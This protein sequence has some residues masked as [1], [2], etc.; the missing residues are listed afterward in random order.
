MSMTLKAVLTADAS[1]FKGE[2]KEAARATGELG[3]K[4]EEAG[5]KL[6][7][8]AQEGAA[9]FGLLK[10]AIAG[11]L[12]V[13]SV[14]AMASGVLAIT[15]ANDA[16]NQQVA[17]LGMSRDAVQV[18]GQAGKRAG[19]EIA[20]VFKDMQEKIGE[21]A[22]TGGG[23]A[24][25]VFKRLKLDVN[26]LV[27]LSP[28]QQLLKIAEAMSKVKDMSR[29]EK[30]F[31]L[32]SL[33]NDATKLL[34]LLDN[35]AA[36]LRELSSITFQSGA[37][38][39]E[40]QNAVLSEASD[41]INQIQLALQGVGN[42]AG[43]AGAELLN[44]VSGDVVSGII[45]LKDL[46]YTVQNDVLMM[47]DAWS[48]ALASADTDAQA[49]NADAKALFGALLEW[50]RIGWTYFP[51]WAG[52]AYTAVH[53]YGVSFGHRFNALNYE[54][55]AVWQHLFAE[56]ADIAGSVFGLI[57][58]AAG[59]T[60][61]AIVGSIASSLE[62]ASSALSYIPGLDTLSGDLGAAA[63]GLRSME[64][65]A[66]SV[67]DGI[68]ASMAGAAA[69]YREAAKAQE[70]GARTATA[71]ANAA[72]VNA[73]YAL[74]NAAAYQQNAEQQRVL[75]LEMGRAERQFAALG[76]A[77]DA[78]GAAAQRLYVNQEAVNKTLQG[79]Q[80]ASKSAA[81]AAKGHADAMKKL[82]APWLSGS[83]AFKAEIEAAAKRFDVDANL[84]K[85]VIQQE[86]GFLKSA[87]SQLKAV[88]PVGAQGIMQLMPPT[89]E[90]VAKEIGL[91]NY[92]LFNA[93][94][95]ITLGAAYLSQQMEKYNGDVAK[96]AAA[97]NAGPG[98]VDKYAGIPP[99]KETQ[100][101]VKNVMGYY[102]DLTKGVDQSGESQVKAILKTEEAQRAASEKLIAERKRQAERI[103]QEQQ[104]LRESLD[105]D[106][107]KAS[108]TKLGG[109]AIDLQGKGFNGDDLQAQVAKKATIELEGL[110]R[111]TAANRA[112][113]VLSADAYRV[114]QLV[115]EEG[116]AP[117]VAQAQ[118]ALEGQA[119][120]LQ[121][122]RGVADKAFQGIGDAL[123]ATAMT[124]KADW[125]GLMDSIISETMRLAVIQPFVKSLSDSFL[126]LSGGGNSGGN[127]ILGSIGSAL[128]LFANGGAFTG[129]GVQAFADGGAFHNSVLTRPTQF[130]ANGG[131]AVAGEAGDEAVM[132]LTR[133]NGQLGV[134]AQVQGGSQPAPVVVQ[135]QIHLH[136]DNRSSNAT[137]SAT[138]ERGSDGNISFR[139]VV[140]QVESSIA[141]RARRGQGLANIFRT[142]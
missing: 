81:E 45:S 105:T 98:A 73:Q 34:P 128:G 111:A 68:R 52:A 90:E 91:T 1:G 44:A 17:Y 41:N 89:A 135:P 24:A 77:V 122:L 140:D 31:L 56:M 84:V 97:Y 127:G 92:N 126:S 60:A 9:A 32:E 7:R 12:G 38:L 87:Q 29:G 94:D 132:P 47:G 121:D 123:L 80:S 79:S 22:S 36:K 104:K 103:A 51:V 53:E 78:Q 102:K 83:V 138:E 46:L 71:A 114:W 39:D 95:N 106:L 130:F 124:G 16:I 66:A 136:V 10:G 119:K 107:A 141:D 40:S 62:T 20:D 26:D 50:M 118:V 113:A 15:R 142:R 6:S 125:K 35:N 42:V 59:S 8:G 131:L 55:G 139:L 109:F 116:F 120:T 134:M 23:E 101:Y 28:D 25:D 61:A 117:S 115:N 82:D 37:I 3:G 27:S 100:T 48:V 133:I 54:L 69:G 88:S 57:G 11:A 65:A 112:E 19:V 137:V 13:L 30:S 49:F 63:E 58:D 99:Y 33:G 110:R 129:Q 18:W 67:G 93:A 75:N 74:D 21:F 64:T 76:S 4:G 72:S 2:V 85:A 96:V 86:T 14:D 43:T 70:D 5:R 108:T